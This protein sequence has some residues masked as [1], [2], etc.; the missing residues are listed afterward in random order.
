MRYRRREITPSI[1]C[2]S[3]CL[4]INL[5]IHQDVCLS[6]SAR[7]AFYPSIRQYVCPSVCLFSSVSRT[8]RVPIVLYVCL[9]ARQSFCL[10][11]YRYTFLSFITYVRTCTHAHARTHTLK[12]KHIF[13]Q[14]NNSKYTHRKYLHYIFVKC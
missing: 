14:H 7:P 8:A 11:A 13:T 3:V 4:F 9:S 10:H 2:L 12:V 1:R 6:E 5:L